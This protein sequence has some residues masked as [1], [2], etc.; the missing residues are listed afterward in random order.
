MAPPAFL[1][2]DDREELIAYLDG[3]LDAERARTV[4]TRLSLDHSIR[5]EAESVKRA[6]DLLDYLPKAE[7]SSTFTSR[8]LDK[9]PVRKTGKVPKPLRRWVF[10]AGWAAV[11]LLALGGGYLAARLLVAPRPA[12]RD[13]VRELRVIENLR[14]Y[15]A[16]RDLD[17]LRELDR[18]DLFG[19]DPVDS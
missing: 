13:L 6:W 7:P 14:L 17:F 2:D 18:S 19:E 3:E 12:E 10:R 1:S 11:V 15:E 5:A 4:E 9:L 8:T 16:G